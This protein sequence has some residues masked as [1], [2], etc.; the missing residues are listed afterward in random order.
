MT[1]ITSKPAASGAAH[2]FALQSLDAQAQLL[3]YALAFFAVGL[4]ALVWMATYA[5][6]G[7][8]IATS[9]VVFAINWAM[10]YA[11]A[12]WMRR[13]PE[14]LTQV[15][16]R[17]RIHVMGG[18]L[19]SASIA[20]ITVLALYAGPA[21]E[22][23]LLAAVGAAVACFFFSAPSL[24]NLLIV[25]PAA[26]AGPLAALYLDPDSRFVGRAAWAA[27][28]LTMALSLVLNRLLRR[29]FALAAEREVLVEQRLKSLAHAETLA[30]SKSD[31]LA[32]L[33]HEI[34]NGLTGVAHVLAS[35]VGGGGR[36][37]P[38]REQLTAALDAAQDLIGVLDAT[39]DSETADAGALSVVAKPFDP[40]RLVRGLVLLNRPAAAAKSLELSLHVDTGLDGPQGAALGDPVRARQILANLIGNAL[41]Y[42][43]RG[44]VEVRITRRDETGVRIEVDDTG[45]GL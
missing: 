18:L 23:I 33:S 3:P 20:Q 43:V 11:V 13:S 25:G 31:I 10:F 15:R 19:W 29:Q 4:P 32:T 9:L 17:T 26:A 41:K 2:A 8:W 21:K 16:R 44:R 1:P 14:H 39:L 22:A 5:Q 24:P 42:T 12:G 7:P 40:A 6:D 28:A 30:K 35:A 45:P 34:R 27:I 37:A 38:S 36:S